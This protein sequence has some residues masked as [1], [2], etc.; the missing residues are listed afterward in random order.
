[1]RYELRNI[2]LSITNVILLI[3]SAFLIARILFQ[4]LGANSTTP[5][6]SWVYDVSSFLMTPFR[7]IFNSANLGQNATLDVPA[8][9]ALIAY[10]ILGIFIMYLIRTLTARWTDHGE[11]VEDTAVHSH[12]DGRRAHAHSH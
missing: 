4:I 8:L 6:V 3:I 10:A 2:L 5:F 1:M 12:D 11:D 9:I 7:G